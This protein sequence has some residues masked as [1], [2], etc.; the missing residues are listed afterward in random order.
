MNT[1]GQHWYREYSILSLVL[2]THFT[3]QLDS[4][5]L[6]RFHFLHFVVFCL[7]NVHDN[8]TLLTPD[9]LGGVLRLHKGRHSI[10]HDACDVLLDHIGTMVSVG[11]SRVTLELNKLQHWHINTTTLRWLQPLFCYVPVKLSILKSLIRIGLWP[12]LVVITGHF[13]PQVKTGDLLV[14]P[15]A[16]LKKQ[17][18]LLLW[19]DTTLYKDNF[20]ILCNFGIKR[21]LFMTMD[22]SNRI[23]SVWNCIFC[24]ATYN[25]IWQALFH[26]R[27]IHCIKINYIVRGFPV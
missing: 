24:F 15:V 11:D 25:Q 18:L 10:L 8:R 2:I 23:Y 21:C 12:Q 9:A 14:T 3:L 1:R 27:A 16:H 20:S 13:W 5:G 26:R 19:L 7:K 22:A 17:Q 4:S 6:L